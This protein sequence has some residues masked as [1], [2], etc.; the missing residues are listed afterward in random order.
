ML[1]SILFSVLV[2]GN[3]CAACAPVACAPVTSEVYAV[4]ERRTP[5]RTVV[6]VVCRRHRHKST[7]I[8]TCTPKGAACCAPAACAPAACAPVARVPA[9][10]APVVYVPAVCAPVACAYARATREVTKVKVKEVRV[11]E[12]HGRRHQR[13]EP[14]APS[15]CGP[16]VCSPACGPALLTSP[17]PLPGK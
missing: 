16:A 1:S 4:R 5:V 13:Y 10:C 2:C 17:A 15:A 9:V 11:V 6:G 3:P 8:A 14:S 7:E 12:R